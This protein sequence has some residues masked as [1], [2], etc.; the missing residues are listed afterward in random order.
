MTSPSAGI[1]SSG[2][3]DDT[4]PSGELRALG[5]SIDVAVA[6]R[7]RARVS[8]A[9]PPQ[10]VR[11]RLAPSLR[12][13]LGEVGEEHGEPEPGRDEPREDVLLGGRA[14]RPS[15][16]DGDDDASDLDEEHH[17]VARDSRGSSFRTAGP[18]PDEGG[19]S[20]SDR[21]GS[22]RV[23][24]HWWSS[25]QLQVLDDRPEREDG[26]VGQADDERT[27]P[28]SSPVNSGRAGRERAGGRR[29]PP[30]CGRAIRRWRGP[31]PSGRS[32]R[33]ASRARGSCCTSRCC[34]SRPAKAEPLLL[35]ADVKA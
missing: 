20:S 10:R 6:A 35:P 15:E 19:R 27:T 28:T 16:Q 34:R 12:H 7:L 25:S 32:G 22:S 30:A 14:E 18:P 33:R 4:S 26:E 23:S 31:G 11:L 13:G 3:D 8:R 29:A 2:P 17:R 9:G 24:R 1:I 5:T 21:S